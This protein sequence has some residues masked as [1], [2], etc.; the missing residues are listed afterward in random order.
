[1]H[2]QKLLP[3]TFDFLQQR[4]TISAER[5]FFTEIDAL[6]H[7]F[8]VQIS[9]IAFNINEI[10]ASIVRVKGIQALLKEAISK[11]T[12]KTEVLQMPSATHV[13]LYKVVDEVIGK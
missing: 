3:I 1:M 11:K 12:S 7:T 10:K 8:M 2:C 4:Q 13:N 6:E 9:L 5:G